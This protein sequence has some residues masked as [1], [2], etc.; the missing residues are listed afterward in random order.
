[1]HIRKI[2]EARPS[3][4]FD[5]EDYYNPGSNDN[6]DPDFDYDFDDD[7]TRL[8]DLEN[9]EEWR[10]LLL[11]DDPQAPITTSTGTKIEPEYFEEEEEPGDEEP[12]N[13]DFKDLTHYLK[14]Y[15][16]KCGVT[17]VHVQMRDRDSITVY[18][19]FKSYSYDLDDLQNVLE[20]IT[21][22]DKEIL[23]EFDSEIDFWESTRENRNQPL[24]TVSYF[25][26][27]ATTNN[28][29]SGKAF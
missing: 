2:N 27:G 1:M 24:I 17:Q 18:I 14:L 12:E 20:T 26:K 19:N 3:S 23:D 8:D 25:R 22:V 13:P 9:S 15:F 16:E 29:A 10:K 5:N 11:N 21:R 7:S 6:N 4:D 28:I